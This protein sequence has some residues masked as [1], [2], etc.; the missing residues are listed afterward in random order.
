MKAQTPAQGIL[1][2]RDWGDAK[3]YT[4]VCECQN[5]DHEHHIWVEAEDAG[6]TVHTY[7]TQKTD[8]WSNKI[9]PRYNIDNS[10]YQNIHWFWVGLFNDWYRRVKLAWQVLTKG[11]IKYEAVITM[12]EQQAF[13]YAETLKSAVK[14]VKAFRSKTDPTTKAA[15]K[16][17]NEG[18]CV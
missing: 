4:V 18:D 7:T 14:D 8:Y 16:I 2:N 15:S 17:A 6:V 3:H 11:Y 9:E 12:D 13:N 1:I 5:A 10:I